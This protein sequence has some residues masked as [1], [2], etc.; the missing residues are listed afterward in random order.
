MFAAAW[1]ACCALSDECQASLSTAFRAL[2]DSVKVKRGAVPHVEL[3]RSAL[4]LLKNAK[5]DQPFGLPDGQRVGHGIQVLEE[6][7]ASSEIGAEAKDGGEGSTDATDRESWAHYASMMEEPMKKSG[8]FISGGQVELLMLANLLQVNIRIDQS[9]FEG[10]VCTGKVYEW[11]A[12]RPKDANGKIIEAQA[13]I[14]LAHTL[15]EFGTQH[16]QGHYSAT[17]P[18]S[19]PRKT[20]NSSSHPAN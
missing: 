10:G 3:R 18:P 4:S 14:R 11:E 16:P 9:L 2:Q 20:R 6:D 5:P 15:F 1:K 7:D 13:T 19:E 17:G 8:L 12:V